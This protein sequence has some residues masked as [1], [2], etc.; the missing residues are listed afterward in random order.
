MIF[1]GLTEILD[2]A[3]GA[4]RVPSGTHLSGEVQRA[5][6]ELLRLLG[7]PGHELPSKG[8][9]FQDLCGL[10]SADLIPKTPLNNPNHVEGDPC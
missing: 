1:K 4:R 6:V 2:K 5:E 9:Q 10:F 3:S 7:V 8:S